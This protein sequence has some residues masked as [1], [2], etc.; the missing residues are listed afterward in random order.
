MF[1]IMT[2]RVKMNFNSSTK[3]FKISILTFICWFCIAVFSSSHASSFNVPEKLIYDLTWAGIK[4][5]TASLEVVD[6]G[7]KMRIVSIARSATWLSVFYTVDDKVE[8]ILVKNENSP[9]ESPHSPLWKRGAEGDFKGGKGGFSG[10]SLFIG[11][12]VNYRLKIREGRHRKD[13]EVIFDHD[14]GKAIYIDYLENEKKEFDMPSH[15]FDPISS[16]YYLRNH[17]LVVG[18]SVYVTIF[19]SKKIWNVEVQVLR[20]EKVTLPIG[21]FDTIVVKPLMKSEG[22]FYRKGDIYIWLTDDIKRIPVKMQTKVA[23]GHVTATLVRGSY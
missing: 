17:K 5:G 21:T 2:N 20:R 8:S 18:E 1:T 3:R 4:A 16:F 9:P 11:K 6:D 22:I 10:E 23:V 14:N 7:D 15:V 13:K 12:P 19:D